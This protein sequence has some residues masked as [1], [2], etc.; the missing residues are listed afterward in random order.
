MD[1]GK[2]KF[3]SGKCSARAQAIPTPCGDCGKMLDRHD[4]HIQNHCKECRSAR[5]VASK[6][7]A[8]RRKKEN[9]TRDRE[10]HIRDREQREALLYKICAECGEAFKAKTKPQR[11]CREHC[12]NIAKKRRRQVRKRGGKNVRVPSLGEIYKRDRGICQLC[13][14]RVGRR[15]YKWPHSRYPSLDHIVPISKGGPDDASNIQLAH[16]GCNKRKQSKKCGSQ[17]R[18]F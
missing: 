5:R 17:R 11:F 13:K 4:G 14:K 16:L 10:Q 1:H 12:N 8:I 18:L 3:C 9:D 6:V 7:E 2:Q 15:T